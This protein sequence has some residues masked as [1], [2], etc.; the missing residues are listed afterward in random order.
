MSILL[1]AATLLGSQASDAAEFFPLTPGTKWHYVE[2]SQMGETNYVDEAGL[3]VQ[4]DGK[5]AI[6]VTTT[7]NGRVIDTR[8]FRVE[9]DTA[10]WVAYGEKKVLN[11]PQPILKVGVRRTTWNFQGDTLFIN[12]STPLSLRCESNHKGRQKVL[13]LER[14]V[15]EVKQTGVLG[16]DR[17]TQV[18]GKQVALYARGVGL[19]EFTSEQT[20]GA[21]KSRSRLRLVRFEPGRTESP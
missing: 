16:G 19:F 3:P 17:G 15:L 9:G 4:I 8:Y 18:T 12:E 7:M 5:A 13:D 10:Y 21:S 2:S 11:P 1:L 14:E 6:P 20:F